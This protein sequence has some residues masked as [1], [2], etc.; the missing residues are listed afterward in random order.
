[1]RENIMKFG[2]ELGATLE[3]YVAIFCIFCNFLHFTQQLFALYA[4]TFQ[5]FTST[6]GQCGMT[7]HVVLNQQFIFCTFLRIISELDEIE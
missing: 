6:I 5:K 4:A 7:S 3:V 2:R 1:M